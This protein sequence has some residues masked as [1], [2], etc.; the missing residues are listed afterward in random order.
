M[1]IRL[2][3]LQHVIM[4]P[5]A[6][7]PGTMNSARTD[8]RRQLDFSAVRNPDVSLINAIQALVSRRRDPVSERDIQRWFRATP[9]AFV[10][11]QLVLMAERGHLKTVKASRGVTRYW[12]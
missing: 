10:S 7:V 11:I 8:Y 9:P 1:A 12:I 4:G 6:F 3:L 5:P 2:R